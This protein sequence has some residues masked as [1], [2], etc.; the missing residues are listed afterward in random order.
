MASNYWTDGRIRMARLQAGY[1]RCN[2]IVKE[3]VEIKIS[4]KLGSPRSDFRST[5]RRWC[6]E[7]IDLIK[8]YRFWKSQAKEVDG[9]EEIPTFDDV[10]ITFIAHLM[11]EIAPNCPGFAKMKEFRNQIAHCSLTEIDDEL[12]FDDWFRQIEDAVNMLFDKLQEVLF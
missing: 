2:D 4:E 12:E 1:L 8:K 9:G 10:D 6:H 11:K 5:W 3:F 7:N